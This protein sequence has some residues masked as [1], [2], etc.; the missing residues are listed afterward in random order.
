MR[1]ITTNS[2]NNKRINN[3]IIYLNFK[4]LRKLSITLRF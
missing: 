3:E 1:Y 4:G 2:A